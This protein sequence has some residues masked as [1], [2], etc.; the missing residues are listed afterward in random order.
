MINYSIFSQSNLY[1]P[2]CIIQGHMKLLPLSIISS[3][4]K[5]KNKFKVFFDDWKL[6]Q[7]P[8][9]INTTVYIS[10]L[11]E[12]NLASDVGPILSLFVVPDFRLSRT[13]RHYHQISLQDMSCRRMTLT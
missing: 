2:L 6:G 4:T 7:I 12:L 8:F 13:D 1:C 5:A 9:F 3:S 11:S 10:T